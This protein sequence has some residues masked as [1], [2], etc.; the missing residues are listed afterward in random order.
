MTAAVRW[1]R[2]EDGY[3]PGFFEVVGHGEIFW[4]EGMGEELSA[5]PEEVGSVSVA[6]FRRALVRFHRFEA[7]PRPHFGP[8]PDFWETRLVIGEV[9]ELDPE[10][11]YDDGQDLFFLTS[12]CLTF[13][14]EGLSV[15]RR[16]L[17]QGRGLAP[18]DVER[19]VRSYLQRHRCSDVEVSVEAD[20]EGDSLTPKVWCVVTFSPPTRGKTIRELYDLSRDVNDLLVTLD[21]GGI[22]MRTVPVMLRAG[23][24][25]LLLGQQESQ[26]LEVK[27][28]P[29]ALDSERARV[30]L[31]QD[32]A[33]FANAEDG[34]LLIVGAR[35]RGRPE[36]ITAICP[37]DLVHLDAK[38]YRAVLD[39]RVFPPI[40]GLQVDVIEHD[41]GGLLVIV[42]PPQPEE[43]QPF[44]VHGA[45]VGGRVEGAFI[46]IVRRRGEASIPISPAAIHAML[47]AGRALLRGSTQG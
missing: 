24:A 35:T 44:L 46:S 17:I 23:R 2:D 31:A 40:E 29:Y 45:V 9:S 26:W 10:F 43:L 22:T 7:E 28:A 47:S 33:R 15:E 6:D 13:S 39:S 21:H 30:E 27:S 25:S 37:V 34:G 18:D 38:R 41:G 32:G 5:F 4:D 14:A 3:G 8:V 20:R 1:H 42:V 16:Y 19:C 11:E 12:T 36:V